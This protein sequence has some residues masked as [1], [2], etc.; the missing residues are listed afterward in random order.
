MKKT[1]YVF[2]ESEHI[3]A[4]ES[5]NVHIFETQ[6]NHKTN[7]FSIPKDKSLCGKYKVSSGLVC[8]KVAAENTNEET[9]EKAREIAKNYEDDGITVCG[10]CVATLYRDDV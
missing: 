1:D 3:D 10:Q 2:I 4:E 8:G 6:Y 9:R 7:K 5:E